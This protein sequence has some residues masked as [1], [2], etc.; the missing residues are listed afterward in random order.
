VGTADLGRA[1]AR[2]FLFG[3][4]GAATYSERPPPIVQLSTGGRAR[5]FPPVTPLDQNRPRAASAA[6]SFAAHYSRQA[7]NTEAERQACEIRLRAERRTGELTETLERSQ[8]ARTDLATSEQPAPKSYE[9]QLA[10]AGITKRQARRW[11]QLAAVAKAE[12][13]A[14]FAWTAR[15]GPEPSGGRA[16]RQIWPRAA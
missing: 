15:A 11:Q 1:A 9:Q 4:P 7:R 14:A 3:V 10:D 6:L 16:Y 5:R 13:E 12:F 2:P 8:G